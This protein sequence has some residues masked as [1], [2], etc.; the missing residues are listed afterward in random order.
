MRIVSSD[1]ITF[2]TSN[3]DGEDICIKDSCDRYTLVSRDDIPMLIEV[4]SEYMAETEKLFSASTP[5]DAIIGEEHD[6]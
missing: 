6:A 3:S 2:K 5:F 4:L 1:L